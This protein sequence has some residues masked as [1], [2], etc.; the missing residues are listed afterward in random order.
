MELDLQSL[1]GLIWAQWHVVYT[2]VPIGWDPSTL[3]LP[4][5][6]TR[7]RGRYW[8]AKIDDISLWP[9]A[10]KH[11]FLYFLYP[12]PT[13]C[14]CSA[15]AFPFWSMSLIYVMAGISS[16]CSYVHKRT[17][18]NNRRIS[19]C[20]SLPCAQRTSKKEQYILV[21]LKLS[22]DSIRWRKQEKIIIM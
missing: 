21:Q 18:C 19:I 13:K 6:W 1:F 14:F 17:Q 8:S 3:P 16:I 15:H 7:I 5:A 4:T 20:W 12:R 22:T 11:G 10:Q 2:A 9:P